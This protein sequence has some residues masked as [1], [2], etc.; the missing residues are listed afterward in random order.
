[1]EASFRGIVDLLSMQAFFW[2]E[3]DSGARPQ[4]VPIPDEIVS[5]VEA[6]R[7]DMVER[8]AET[9]DELTMRYL[10]GDEIGADELRAAL[11]RATVGNPA[12]PVPCGSALRNR[13]IQRVLDAVVYYLPSPLDIPPI[14][15]DN[16]ST[17]KNE[18]RHPSAEEPFAAL[19]F[20][21]VTD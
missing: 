11:R 8:I 17:G 4:A 20:K 2:S 7:H 16:P 12:T 10:E 1:S 21:I 15:G 18:E 6:A 19:V 5:D 14:R 9:D 3:D 13:G